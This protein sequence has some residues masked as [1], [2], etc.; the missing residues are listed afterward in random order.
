MKM[1]IDQGFK[2]VVMM[3]L[4]YFYSKYS[5]ILTFFLKYLLFAGKNILNDGGKNK[6]VLHLVYFLLI[7]LFN[8]NL[9][10]NNLCLTCPGFFSIRCVLTAL[11]I[12]ANLGL[13]VSTLVIC[14][15]DCILHEIWVA[16]IFSYH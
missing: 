14:Q 15:A 8:T 9:R 4:Y 16:I 2:K 13:S 3:S 6:I 5:N 7:L 12:A 1:K 11:G 10:K